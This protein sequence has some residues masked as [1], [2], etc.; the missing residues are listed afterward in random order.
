MKLSVT[1]K[2]NINSEK[3]WELIS[4]FSSIKKFH[5][6]F[7][8]CSLE[9]EGIGSIRKLTLKDGSRITEQLLDVDDKIMSIKYSIISSDLPIEDFNGKMEI[10]KI[11]DFD[12]ELVWSCDVE[13][14]GISNEKMEKMMTS[15]FVRGIKGIEELSF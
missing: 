9:G 12:S 13:P 10:N 6:A 1:Q 3:L 7:D 15:F 11:N 2:L 8:E 14:S 5:P 4:D